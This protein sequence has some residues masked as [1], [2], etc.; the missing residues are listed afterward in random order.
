[1]LENFLPI[2]DAPNYEI[3]SELICRNRKTKKVLTLQTDYKNFKY[4]SL[5]VTGSRVCIQRSPKTL[6]AQAVEAA[7]PK[8]SFEPIP[9][10]DGRYEIN[11]RGVVRNAQS[12]KILKSHDNCVW[13]RVGEKCVVRCVADLLWEVHGQIIKRRYRPQPCTA[14]NAQGKFFFS[15]MKA[16][17]RFLTPKV[18]FSVSCIEQRLCRRVPAIGEW[19]ITYLADLT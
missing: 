3:N 12:K 6:R 18:F 10:T 11:E 5:R 17:A 2:P 19:K 7:K 1:M 14:E 9:S 13:L 15:N 4:Y 16:C 8:I